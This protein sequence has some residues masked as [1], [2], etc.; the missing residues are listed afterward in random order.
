MPLI[1]SDEES[2][3]NGILTQN[4]NPLLSINVSRCTIYETCI[5]GLRPNRMVND[6]IV[7]YLIG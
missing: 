5:E 2:T 3:F 6:T 1:V 4:E 7:K